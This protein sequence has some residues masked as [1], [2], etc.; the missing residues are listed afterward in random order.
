MAELL[1][2]H[3]QHGGCLAAREGEADSMAGPAVSLGKFYYLVS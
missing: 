1:R 2:K 3:L